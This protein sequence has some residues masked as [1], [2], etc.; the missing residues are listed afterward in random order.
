MRITRPV[1]TRSPA[2]AGILLREGPMSADPIAPYATQR[3]AEQTSDCPSHP[4]GHDSETA[5]DERKVRRAF[6]D[7][8]VQS[9]KRP[10]WW[11][12][13]VTTYFRPR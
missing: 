11:S 9:A 4:D 6:A 5:N 2:Q 3:N 1:Q 8:L 10:P 7:A 13:H 12:R